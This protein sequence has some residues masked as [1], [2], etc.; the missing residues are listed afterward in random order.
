MPR[1]HDDQQN[2][3]EQSRGARTP[4]SFPGGRINNA[5]W[6]GPLIDY[7][8]VELI[9]RFMT[10]SHKILSR[11]RAGTSAQEQSA[12]KAAAKRARFLALLP[13]TGQQ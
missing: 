1:D 12:L 3:I 2:V 11:K 7:K 5:E 10:T 4:D 6:V 9:R 8:E 13:Y